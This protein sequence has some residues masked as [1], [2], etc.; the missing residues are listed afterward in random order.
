[1]RLV[2]RR[3]LVQ[4]FIISVILYSPTYNVQD[5][6]KNLFSLCIYLIV[7]FGR[8]VFV[9][10]CSMKFP[11]HFIAVGN[12]T[13]LVNLINGIPN[14]ISINSHTQKFANNEHRV[15]GHIFT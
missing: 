12:Q 5:I 2:C 10:L 7:D 15:L 14:N 6:I 8:E 9:H 3:F 13:A 11:I 4:L 1:V